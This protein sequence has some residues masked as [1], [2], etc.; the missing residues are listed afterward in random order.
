MA[1]YGLDNFTFEII[2]NTYNLK[3]REQYWVDQLKPSY[4]IRRAKREIE[5]FEE[6]HKQRSKAW[7]NGHRD[8]Y[9]AKG[10][11]YRKRLCLYE[12][13]ILTLG[14]LDSR[15]RYMGI[16]SPYAVAKKYLIKE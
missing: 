1:S 14:V 8:E 3:E 11:A 7:Y 15:F 4:N 6:A 13:E 10:K 12:G 9:L 5:D 2:E 16:P